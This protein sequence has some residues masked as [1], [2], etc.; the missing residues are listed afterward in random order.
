MKWQL[1][2]VRE[3]DQ[4][5]HA[6]RTAPSE[7]TIRGNQIEHEGYRCTIDRYFARARHRSISRF[8]RELATGVRVTFYTTYSS[9][10]S[11]AYDRF[12]TACYLSQSLAKG[13][14][15]RRRDIQ[16]SAQA[17]AATAEKCMN[18]SRSR[19]SSCPRFFRH[20]DRMIRVFPIRI[21]IAHRF[22]RNSQEFSRDGSG[23][24]HKAQHFACIPSGEP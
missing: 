22:E 14:T 10:H 21:P 5:R 19:F 12:I 1:H 2:F 23:F 17:N 8:S 6:R 13:T 4:A 20:V 11:L 15:R 7:K 18:Q 3:I 24:L 9:T 16:T